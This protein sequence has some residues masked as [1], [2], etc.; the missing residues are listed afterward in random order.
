MADD[1]DNDLFDDD[2]DDDDGDEGQVGDDPDAVAAAAEA[3]AKAKAEAKAK[4]AKAKADTDAAAV[5]N[6]GQAQLAEL[7]LA[8][9]KQS[10][11][12]D[13]R[14][15]GTVAADFDGI[16]LKG[17]DEAA[18][19]T[20][21]AEAKASHDAKV[22]ALAAQGF[23][24]NPQAQSDAAAA[25]A[26]DAAEVAAAQQWGAMGPGQPAAMDEKLQKLVEDEVK[27]GD[28]MGT[29]GSLVGSGGLGEFFIRGRR[30][31]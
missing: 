24:F 16:G 19:A 3:D 30:G 18:K 10:W 11:V 12:N 2:D 27:K 21:L 29:I 26:Q 1:S 5:A 20:F 28:V 14:A 9:L 6:A 13:A 31:K 8:A 25:A 22:A 7:G 23:V 17:I 15:A 4:A